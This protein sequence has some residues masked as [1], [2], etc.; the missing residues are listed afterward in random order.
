MSWG[1]FITLEGIDGSGT[2]TQ[3]KKI[4]DWLA[5]KKYPHYLTQEPSNLDV[6]RIIRKYLKEKDLPP[7]LDALAFACD[8]VDH[9]HREILPRLGIG[10]IVISD[11]FIDSSIA[12]QSAQGLDMDWIKIINQFAYTPNLTLLLDIDAQS[13][14]MRRKNITDPKDIEKYENIEFLELVRQ[15]YIDLA[16]YSS[17]FVIINAKK[18]VEDVTSECIAHIQKFIDTF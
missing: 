12:Y 5:S 7:A 9:C 6:G 1:I 17:R 2:T 4:G 18:S 3:L 16:K 14:Y 13:G 10:E 11:R 15:K 8:R